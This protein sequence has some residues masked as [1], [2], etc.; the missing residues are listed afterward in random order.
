[1]DKCGILFV[2]IVEAQ[3][4][5]N[6]D[7]WGSMDPFCIVASQGEEFRTKTHYKGHKNPVWKE[8]FPIKVNDI[9]APITFRVMEEDTLSSEK[10]GETIIDIER[11]CK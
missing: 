6:T 1:M 8:K 2:E 7:S 4:E 9:G 3:L 10:V 11:L 5:R